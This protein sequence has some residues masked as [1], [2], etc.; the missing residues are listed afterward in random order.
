[1]NNKDNLQ[2]S[3]KKAFENHN[4]PL[5]NH[6]WERLNLDLK[7]QQKKSIFS[8]WN[9]AIAL[10][11]IFLGAL[12][13]FYLNPNTTESQFSN[14]VIKEQQSDNESADKVSKN[15]FKNQD[16][17]QFHQD[18]A[19]N[20]ENN[21]MV[22]N[23]NTLDNKP[24]IAESL[25]PSKEKLNTIDQ[26]NSI[27]KTIL[28]D[29]LNSPN[30]VEEALTTVQLLDN[31][32]SDSVN[33]TNRTEDEKTN[34]TEPKPIEV[35]NK[36]EDSKEKDSVKTVAKVST[37]KVKSK[38]E[39]SKMAVFLSYGLSSIQTAN[40]N[41]INAEAMH[42]DG[43]KIFQ[44]SE[45]G[46]ES[47]VFNLGFEFYIRK[48][49]NLIVQ[50]GTQYRT[51]TNTENIDYHYTDIPF[52]NVDGSIIGYFRDTINPLRIASSNILKRR[53]V[54]IPVQ[55]AYSFPIAKKHELQP[56][57]GLNFNKLVSA[58]GN[59]F[60]VNEGEAKSLN[61]IMSK[62]INMGMIA[63]LQ[64]NYNLRNHWWVGL[65]AQWQQNIQNSHF[66]YSQIQSKI[67]QYNCNIVLKYKF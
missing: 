52:R 46:K 31:S 51:I 49:F 60:S 56:S 30:K 3:F 53:Y 48:N 29:K 7:N 40:N 14:T 55:F 10:G 47:Q 42:K 66:G 33:K 25:N 26:S 64:Y 39:R 44:A 35:V 19:I 22:S 27:D 37:P 58:S 21:A 16:V 41:I 2:E 11:L 12:I 34:T 62:K 32:N 17:E 4:E 43:E 45:Q 23:N 18:K 38:E 63:G 5:L 1:M 8:F 59:S 36:I 28:D 57:I 9:I 67:N 20:K 13:G 65:G 6:Q 54:T 24:T 50:T 15:T 61:T